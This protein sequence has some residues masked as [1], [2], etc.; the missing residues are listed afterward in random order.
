MTTETLAPPPAS[1]AT[2]RRARGARWPWRR[3]GPRP[4]YL[5][6]GRI[7]LDAADEPVPFQTGETGDR[8]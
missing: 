6:Y 5:H 8:P 1:C 2:P 7:V 4:R 3:A